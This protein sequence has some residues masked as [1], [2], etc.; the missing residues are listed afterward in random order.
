[1][2]RFAFASSRASNEAMRRAS[3]GI[4]AGFGLFAAC[5][6][7]VGCGGGSGGSIPIEQLGS[8][9]ASIFCHKVFTCCDAAERSTETA[10]MTDE[11]TCRMLVGADVTDNLTSYQTSI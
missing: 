4:G 5:A 3:V 1:M 7:V 2:P 10:T 6:L 9:Y 8:E 11:A